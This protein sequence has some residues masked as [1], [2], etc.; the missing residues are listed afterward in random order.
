[1]AIISWND[2]KYYF[3]SDQQNT[4][5]EV[6]DLYQ[7]DKG[8][9]YVE[10][11]FSLSPEVIS[12][13]LNSFSPPSS[14]HAVYVEFAKFLHGRSTWVSTSYEERK[15]QDYASL[16]PADMQAAVFQMTKILRTTMSYASFVSSGYT[17]IL[18]HLDTY[19]D[20]KQNLLY[21]FSR[22]MIVKANQM[23]GVWINTEIQY[24]NEEQLHVI[25]FSNFLYDQPYF[26]QHPNYDRRFE[27]IT[28][29][30]NEQ[31]ADFF[32]RYIKYYQ[33]PRVFAD[34]L[35]RDLRSHCTQVLNQN[36]AAGKEAQ[37]IAA[38]YRAPLQNGIRSFLER[39][40][41]RGILSGDFKEILS[42]PASTGI[43]DNRLCTGNNTGPELMYN[44]D[45]SVSSGGWY[46]SGGDP[47]T[48]LNGD[49]GPDQHLRT[50]YFINPGSTY[51][52]SID[53]LSIT[54]STGDTIL[55]GST[56]IYTAS[57][58]GVQS[59]TFTAGSDTY[60]EFSIS[61]FT[62]VSIREIVTESCDPVATAQQPGSSQPQIDHL[63]PVGTIVA[64]DSYM[65]LLNE[66]STLT[67]T[68]TAG[69]AADI[70]SG[71]MT[72]INGAA[73]EWSK[74]TA[75]NGGSYLIVTG[76]AYNTPFKLEVISLKK[77][78]LSLPSGDPFYFAYAAE[79]LGYV[80]T[81]AD[82]EHLNYIFPGQLSGA[83]GYVGGYT[84]EATEMDLGVP[85]FL[86]TETTQ[87]NGF[88]SI[89][90]SI[91]KPFR[92]YTYLRI[93]LKDHQTVLTSAYFSVQNGSNTVNVIYYN[94]APATPAY[95]TIAA[96]VSETGLS[97]PPALATFLS[98]YG[99]VNLKQIREQGGLKYMTGLPVAQ[100]D[101]AVIALDA[102]ADLNTISYDIKVNQNL[103]NAGIYSLQDLNNMNRTD[104]V[105]RFMQ[106]SDVQAG[107]FN[108]MKIHAVSKVYG[109]L[110]QSLITGHRAAMNIPSPIGKIPDLNAVLEEQCICD[111]CDA[112]VSPL[113]YLTDLLN[114]TLTNIKY[115][116]VS[117]TFTFLE[118]RFYQN[119]KELPH[120]CDAEE[121]LIC[122][123]RVVVE[124][125]RRYIKDPLHIPTSEQAAA[126]AKSEKEYVVHAYRYLLQ[127]FGTSY[128]ELRDVRVGPDS[129]E[130]K[131][132]LAKRLNIPYTAPGPDAYDPFTVLFIDLKS[133]N[134]TE[135]YLEKVFGLIDTTRDCMCTGL[136]LNDSGNQITRWALSGFSWNKNTDREGFVYLKIDSLTNEVNIYKNS[137]REES[138]L[139]GIAAEVDTGRYLIEAANESDL[140][141][142]LILTSNTNNNTIYISLVP[143][144]TSW[145]LQNQRNLWRTS[146]IAS[147]PYYE[148]TLPV[149]EPDIIGPDD[150]REPADGNDTF[151]VWKN[152]RAWTDA[153]LTSFSGEGIYIEDILSIMDD[154]VSYTRFDTTIISHAAWAS[155]PTYETM[156]GLYLALK[157][158]S[159]AAYDAALATITD[160]LKLTVA[161]FFRLFELYQ[162]TRT[163]DEKG[164]S[165]V[166]ETAPVTDVKQVTSLTFAEVKRG[167]VFTL[168]INGGDAITHIADADDTATDV[169][170]ALG[171]QIHAATSGGWTTVD[172]LNDFPS[173][174]QPLVL[175]ATASN[176][177]FTITATI[178]RSAT[179]SELAEIYSILTQARKITFFADWITEEKLGA[180]N[181][182]L[183]S[184]DF[185]KSLAEPVP[186]TWP[187]PVSET[188]PFI[189]PELVGVKE[190]AEPTI[191]A[192]AIGLWYDRTDELETISNDIQSRRENISLDEAFTYS[193]GEDYLPYT[194]T[195][196]P[197]KTFYT[198]D[199]VLNSLNNLTDPTEAAYAEAYIN[200]VLYMSADDFRALMAIRAKNI[201][202]NPGA[203]S[204]DE[205]TTMYAL[206]TTSYK[207][208]VS[209]ATWK[210]EEGTL[211]YWQVRK[212][213]L[214]IW[215]A[216][217]GD[218][219][220]WSQSLQLIMRSPAI[221]PDIVRPDYI[222]SLDTGTPAITL[223]NNRYDEVS[224][225]FTAI[226]D[227]RE[228]HTP[229]LA[230]FDFIILTHLTAA[231]SPLLISLQEE[232]LAGN[233]IADKLDQL[234]I[235][236]EMLDFLLNIRS[237]A[238]T[239]PDGIL[240]E[241]W[242]EVYSIL[243][244]ANKERQFSTWFEEEIAAGVFLTPDF[245]IRSAY[246]N[247]T[248]FTEDQQ[249]IV[250]RR[251]PDN[252]VSN[253]QS[254]LQ[255]R[256]D[257][258]KAIYDTMMDIVHDTEETYIKDLRDALVLATDVAGDTLSEKAKAISDRLLIDAENNCCQKVTRIS[259]AIETLQGIFFS[260]RNGILQDTYPGLNMRIV[261]DR[262]DEEWIW[263]GSYSNWRSA[264]FVTLYPE[265]LLYPTYRAQQSA[266][267]R[268]FAG[269]LRD[270]NRLTPD[271]VCKAVHDY[272]TYYEDVCNLTLVASCSGSTA[273]YKGYGC[274]AEQLTAYKNL[275]HVFA[276]GSKTGRLYWS[277]ID[278]DRTDDYAHS[279]WTPVSAYDNVNVV[280]FLGATP[281]AQSDKQNVLLV[282]AKTETDGQT[283]IAYARLNLD[284]NTWD[285]DITEIDVPSEDGFDDVL[286]AIVLNKANEATKVPVV[287]IAVKRGPKVRVYELNKKGS[288][289]VVS[290]NTNFNSIAIANIY[291]LHAFINETLVYT[292]RVI[293]ITP[294]NTQDLRYL[295]TGISESYD[296]SI[297]LTPKAGSQRIQDKYFLNYFNSF[298]WPD[299]DGILSNDKF[300]ILYGPQAQSGVSPIK[301]LIGLSSEVH[302]SAFDDK[303]QFVP[304]NNKLISGL[305]NLHVYA[306]SSG[307]TFALYQ[308]AGNK[309]GIYVSGIERDSNTQQI[310]IVKNSEQRLTPN[311]SGPFSVHPGDPQAVANYKV[312]VE[313]AYTG[314]Q[315]LKRSGSDYIAEAYYFVPMLAA[316]SLQ[317]KGY[318]TQALD[319]FRLVYDYSVSA[320]G[321]SYNLHPRKIWFGLIAEES[322][323]SDI[324]RIQNWLNDPI[325][326]HAVAENR[327]NSYTRYTVI[328][329]ARCLLDFANSEF[330]KDDAESV[331]KARLLYEE[332]M[333]LLS[334]EQL[335]S[336]EADC[337]SVI[338]DLYDYEPDDAS[339][340]D[341]KPVWLGI[342]T[343]LYKIS[344]KDVLDNT[345][346]LIE[347]KIAGS[348]PLPDKMAYCRD[349]TDDALENPELFTDIGTLIATDRITSR[350]AMLRILRNGNIG[351]LAEDT[352]YK[353]AESYLQTTS[354]V[355]ALPE[356]TLSR[357]DFYLKWFSAE[358]KNVTDTPYPNDY[359]SKVLENYPVRNGM[360]DK[361]FY[362]Y[363]APSNEQ[364]L[365]LSIVRNPIK[366]VNDYFGMAALY[367]PSPNLEF[368]VPPN[369][370][371]NSM[372]LEAEINLYKLRNC[373]N[374]A[375]IVRELAPYA[376][377]TDQFS[378]LPVATA[379]G[380][381][382]TLNAGGTFRPSPYRFDV[383][384]Q[385]AKEQVQLAQQI[386]AALLSMYEKTDAEN[387]SLLRARQDLKVSQSNIKL[388]DL[389]L[390]EA[391]SS[392]TLAELQKDRVMI[393]SDYYNGL[394]QGNS[395]SDLE[396]AALNMSTAITANFLLASAAST[397]SSYFSAGNIS[398]FLADALTATSQYLNQ[399]ASYERRR[400]EW[401]Y[402]QDLT[403][404]D[405]KISD[406]QIKIAT[407]QKNVV[408]QERQI[409]VLQN[410]NA[411][412]TLD[413][414]SNKFTNAELYE[415]MSKVL[416]KVYSYI[417]Q[418]ATSS[419]LTAASQLRFERQLQIPSIIQNDYWEAPSDAV[420]SV[421]G[422]G[423]GP[424][425]RGLTAS[426]RLLQDVTR[427]DQ[428]AFDTDVRKLELT[429]N[430]SLAT[431]DPV[432]FQHFRENGT[433]T[434]QTP[435]EMFDRDFPGHY[436]RLVKRIRVSIIALVP[437]VDGIKA[438]L[439]NPG[440]S[441][442]VVDN[443]FQR[444]PVRRDPERIAL[445]S[446]QNATGMFELT[447]Q[448]LKLNP[449]ESIGVDTFWNFSLPKAANFFDFNSIAD[450]LFTIEY[451]ALENQVYRNTII[452]KLN[453]SYEAARPYSFKNQFADQW[454]DLNNTDS[455][456]GSM[457]VAF[458]TLQ[459]D[460]PA[461]LQNLQIAGITL[462]FPD[463]TAKQN[464]SVEGEDVILTLIPSDN[465]GNV[466]G[467]EV[468][469]DGN[470]IS[471][472]SGNAASWAAMIS[473]PVA[474][475]WQLNLPQKV[476]AK[477]RSEDVSDMLFVIYYKGETAKWV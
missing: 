163:N 109:S 370:I 11:L 173:F 14:G 255:G 360:R 463:G 435:M 187:I 221:D 373:M 61:R 439:I 54:A 56:V 462:Y 355:T 293:T 465:S 115:T 459:T 10:Q 256:T 193:W 87:A 6:N 326:P 316:L 407:D 307:Q 71:L 449:F 460:F 364:I 146:D 472:S 36:P 58:T 50:W 104:A 437:P 139:V 152:R 302:Y 19:P 12:P 188:V 15:W 343:D 247:Q 110:L 278:K 477:I 425:R 5:S 136:K 276:T 267:F 232:G 328:S 374:I 297:T 142:E 208:R 153:Q 182:R 286:R 78:L 41:T 75:S 379:G 81:Y 177:P 141:G 132:K 28:T 468:I 471:T 38:S 227:D 274:G 432:A 44:G 225:L 421:A 119:F 290:T 378:G 201:L 29:I 127:G 284:T 214:P 393:S 150:F 99:I 314:N 80:K 200:T 88:F 17:V 390:K 312:S 408:D 197:D 409:A 31:L 125:L 404:A 49:S 32:A 210:T 411:Q 300:Y 311:T 18:T 245:F 97:I 24:Q 154:S 69:T 413:F 160:D 310:S 380:Q 420:V 234:N 159:S 165:I 117:D 440:I 3:D 199:D 424:D 118:S 20:S 372:V 21:G 334:E 443:T 402:Q 453:N 340:Y 124:I 157:S 226:K 391:Y 303:S 241:E 204:T 34:Y 332:A 67:Y 272:F 322:F 82:T 25:D 123:Q 271:S 389:R 174:T 143:M 385:R 30:R 248:F 73:G 122:Q 358:P 277:T 431:L 51:R 178:L 285:E 60:L 433:I 279:Y 57:N 357:T 22:F 327:Q 149:I 26:I 415:W 338:K 401:E 186:G 392:I 356:A 77:E 68:T 387:Y 348:D 400:Q 145:R 369:P 84:V 180:L 469:A 269:T 419:A 144:A 448:S 53:I 352:A 252:A 261:S 42:I 331:P 430:I 384:I 273:S 309:S 196:A 194:Y 320:N 473:R 23:S 59:F 235:D 65:I 151:T 179:D 46:N 237:L 359:A 458:D 13:Y 121:N 1:M 202:G 181:I 222:K 213:Q 260:I 170:K 223:W 229:P 298:I 101:P 103:I 134:L 335:V 253:W 212:A 319:W 382:T 128:E 347:A 166:T 264:M 74:V 48:G 129:S 98:T 464:L 259:Q 249:H 206:L 461:N 265:N 289:L 231:G 418:Q 155:V 452:E 441:Y 107:G 412:A 281:W 299:G 366:A 349:I 291:I 184:R 205:W 333:E 100:D 339:W 171:T 76:N 161:S 191:G 198:L 207:L 346:S 344:D 215:R 72:A 423:S 116:G 183:N 250:R 394:L 457:T 474:G 305:I 454:Y 239:D 91:K 318:Y 429:K 96:V 386:E 292:Q 416:E 317:N 451:T 321:T 381:V 138:E 275:Q 90:Y 442:T 446:A 367:L 230:G 35:I 79:Y 105:N 66:V 85:K 175:Q 324:K 246:S 268:A 434:F 294:T 254:I 257:Q 95:T 16:F 363:V 176:T 167:D 185:W 308:Q 403:N 351:K 158:G 83:N 455:T 336:E 94:D 436:L 414:L 353:L 395:L 476:L 120:Y 228:L 147:T 102:H 168:S 203:V 217:A 86:G 383:L 219:S 140:S 89:G 63:T 2:Y 426:A 218:R 337:Q 47:V 114:Y 172:V 220:V 131:A 325:N 108:A 270:D 27:I 135:A 40:K 106:M 169:A 377:P 427:L 422:S 475:S 37:F 450:I 466:S 306:N 242:S 376:A 283:K 375:G 236:Q 233:T 266:G 52:I 64:G 282:F 192:T 288:E 301:T 164:I 39:L 112:A 111:D 341:W 130:R 399:L 467:K 388:Q 361:A 371:L 209:Y 315:N 70:I 323:V 313:T 350:D 148:H 243:V 240:E 365:T 216:D 410:N 224:A 258:E 92:E 162:A 156:Q 62:N 330:S 428:F 329:I 251:M 189:D 211:I 133:I 55:N 417:L 4:I 43:D 262:F 263:M 406:Q 295:I 195:H 113:A 405:L 438:T 244:Q 444:V 396:R 354:L 456:T 296:T 238:D 33:N 93:D 397:L 280:S 7:T 287:Y 398:G 345:V 137:N 126:L 9:I 8:F 447:Q 368:C 190:L 362:N 470:I 45:F 342:I 304:N 445:T